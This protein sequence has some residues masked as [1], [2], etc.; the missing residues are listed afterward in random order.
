M[1]PWSGHGAEVTC[2]A[3]VEEQLSQLNIEPA[4]IADISY[5]RRVAGRRGGDRIIGHDAWI[6]LKSCEG[7]LIV[8]LSRNCRVEQV[9]TRNKCKF[10][11]VDSY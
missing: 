9:Y 2:N 3:A 4:D 1:F 7:A 11:G 6:N 10:P 8:A 5:L